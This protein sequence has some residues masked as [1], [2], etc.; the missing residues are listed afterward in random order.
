MKQIT[1]AVLSL[2]FSFQNVQSQN[3]DSTIARYANDFGQ[4]RMYLHFDKSS[5][6]PGET[7]W[8]KAYLMKAIFPADE[9]KTIYLDWT[10]EKG[11]L[12]LHSLSPVQDAITFGQF[13]VP[14][15]YQGG[16]IHVKAYTKWMLN[17][18]S[19]F[20]FNKDLRVLSK[21]NIS[22]V[23]KNAI[24]PEIA[25]FPEGG[26]QV[27][28]VINKI[29]F[30]ANDQWGR[31]LKI[32]GIVQNNKNI[33]VDSIRVIHDG[34]G[35]FFINPQPGET[36]SAKWKDEKGAEHVT[37][38][39]SVKSNGVSLQVASIGN[40]RS[41]LVSA[42][43]EAATKTGTLHLI[44]TM[45]QQTVFK[46]TRELKE[47]I[48]QGI[49]PTVDLPSGILTITVFDDKWNPLAERITYINNEE[50]FF[51]PEMSVQHWGLNKR[52]K[53]EIE[54]AVADSLS[55]NLSVSVTDVGIDADSSDNIISHL[56]LTGELKGRVNDPSHYFL[57]NSDSISRQLDLVMLTHGWRRFN[58]E[59]LVKGNFPKIIY[60]KD[61]SYLSISGKIYG[62]SPAQLRGAGDIVLIVT[63]GKQQTKVLPVAIRPDGS[64]N[65]PSMILFD[66]A[67]IYYQLP[68]SK[69]LGDV[70]VQFM[71]NRVP[72]LVQN[73]KANGFFYNY[74]SD[75]SGSSR[76][77]KIADAAEQELK[78]FN[79]K[80]LETVTIKARTKSPLQIMDEKYTS[81]L[82]SGGD[83]YQ[84]DLVND[85]FA[86]SSFSIFNYLQGKVAG[87]QINT[88]SSPPTLQWRGSTPLIYLDE[89]PADAEMISGIPVSD[90]AYVKVLR[91]PFM[92]GSGGSGGAISIYTRKGNDRKSEPGKGLSNNTISGYNNI[93]Q[94]Y[95]PNYESANPD[96][97][98]KDFRTTLYWNPEVITTPGKSKVIL[99]FYNN[100]VSKSFRVV[101]EGMTKDGRL[102]HVEQ[103][104]E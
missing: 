9:S 87:L 77:F 88:T 56:L 33:T 2:F 58:W 61:T 69:G 40:K 57:N 7:I 95:S 5:Y 85:P 24:I 4:E 59:E 50:Y 98:K 19:A 27:S 66:T 35:F 22:T 3:I 23:H 92:G 75:T 84:F 80:V 18:D 62:A 49:I 91:P 99:S 38:L 51:H 64:F 25:F 1:A 47:G 104:M 70:S 68:K 63:Q 73:F 83:A 53:N 74:N 96:N 13:D 11:N 41:F 31:P 16:F 34:M 103:V 79:G 65:D 54:I 29:A 37:E 45:Y 20:L 102:A 82:F 48:I 44:G 67:R 43:P 14:A 101:I 86:V 8:F 39:P 55:S 78:L 32:T 94:F 60:P 76:H 97:E 26:D 46:V 28:G 81:G 89:M 21:N 30:K 72:P 17:F 15:N 10:D 71:Q 90:V 52:A 93:R 100:D 6:S 12:L 42:S 36:F